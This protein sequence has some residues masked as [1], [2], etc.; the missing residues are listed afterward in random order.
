[1]CLRL[2]GQLLE[3]L[4]TGREPVHA[5]HPDKAVETKHVQRITQSV[6]RALYPMRFL[7]LALP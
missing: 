4:L 6:H 5:G 1:M 2:T 3:Y 7:G